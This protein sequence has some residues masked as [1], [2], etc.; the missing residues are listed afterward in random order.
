MTKMKVMVNFCIYSLASDKFHNATW[1]HF[2][3]PTG[4]E[5]GMLIIIVLSRN[6]PAFK[7]RS[8]CFLVF[9]FSHIFMG[10]I[11]LTV[12]YSHG[13]ESGHKERMPT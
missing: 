5:T 6:T 12:R 13:L 10:N 11:S 1:P 8:W 2:G 3:C 7:A 9:V 4:R